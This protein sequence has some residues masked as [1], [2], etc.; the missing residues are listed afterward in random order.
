[1][2]NFITV[3]NQVII[4]FLIILIGIYTRKKGIIDSRINK[5]LIALLLNVTLPMN[6]VSSFN[7]KFS[8][9]MLQN[10]FFVFMFGVLLHP[11]CFLLGKF[12][13]RKHSHSEKNTLIFVTIFSNCGFMAFPLLESIYGRIGILYGSMFLAPFNIFLWTIGVMLFSKEQS[14]KGLRNVFN[15]G[16]ASVIIGFM[17][18]IF[19]ISLPYPLQRCFEVVG[20]MTTPLSM[21]ITGAIIADIEFKVLFSSK[22]IYHVSF[23]RL[24]LI[25]VLVL[26]LLTQLGISGTVMGVCVLISAMPA[27]AMAT[28]LAEKYEGNAI[29][30]SQNVFITTLLSLITIPLFVFLIQF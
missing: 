25:P 21:I 4:I 28:V 12:L 26:V 13:F 16:I 19:S 1:M 2:T 9:D 24:V 20:S 3:F 10:M 17:L 14:R 8:L 23:I 27:A 5:G 6:I 11:I 22:S 29:Y 7:F 30:A 15:P 18:F